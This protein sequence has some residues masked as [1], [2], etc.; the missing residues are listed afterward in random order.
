[1]QKLIALKL[2]KGWKIMLLCARWSFCYLAT[3]YRWKT[4]VFIDQYGLPKG[5]L[6]MLVDQSVHSLIGWSFA[7]GIRT[8]MLQHVTSIP[9]A[10][11]P[12][13]QVR[14][15]DP[16]P[17]HLSKRRWAP[18]ALGPTC[19]MSYHLMT[20]MDAC[21][22]LLRTWRTWRKHPLGGRPV[23]CSF[24][25]RVFWTPTAVWELYLDLTAIKSYSTPHAP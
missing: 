13:P 2:C 20:F 19:I 16:P 14:W 25:K 4:P 24:F 5:L 3:H 6:A 9:R 10:P 15:L 8:M 22:S 11:G 18:G 21:L 23:I 12:Y 1:M 17:K 7:V